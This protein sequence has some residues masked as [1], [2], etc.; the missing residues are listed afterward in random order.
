MGFNYLQTDDRDDYFATLSTRKKYKRYALKRDGFESKWLQK[1]GI[2]KILMAEA[3]F[4][5]AELKT[6][7]IQEMINVLINLG[8]QIHEEKLPYLT[9][10]PLH[11]WE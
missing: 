6:M 11:V 10:H 2:A 3:N 1:S 9:G 7:H 8:Y 5:K 4:S